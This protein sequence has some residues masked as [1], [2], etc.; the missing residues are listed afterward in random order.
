MVMVSTVCGR[1]HER[2][3]AAEVAQSVAD[4]EVA[5]DHHSLDLG[6]S[7]V[8]SPISRIFASR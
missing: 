7:E 4:A 1:E 3:A 5:R 8:P 6:A 2:F